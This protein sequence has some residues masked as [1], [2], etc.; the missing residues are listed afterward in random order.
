MSGDRKRRPQLCPKT[1]TKCF[2][3]FRDLLLKTADFHADP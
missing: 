2:L 1:A 3:D